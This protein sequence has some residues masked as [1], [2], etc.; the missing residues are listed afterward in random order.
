MADP[1][2]APPRAVVLES[3]SDYAGETDNLVDI[4]RDG[5]TKAWFDYNGVLHE[6]T[7][8]WDDLLGPAASGL[9]DAG[10]VTEAFAD[11]AFTAT[12]W[13]YDRDDAICWTLQTSHRWDRTTSLYFHVHIVPMANP[14]T[15]Q[16]IRFDGSYAWASY[17]Q[18][19]PSNSG[20]TAIPA[21][22]HTV[23]PGDG[24]KATIVPLVTIAPPALVLES[25]IL[26]IRVRRPGNSDAA[27]TY[28]TS[29]SPGSAKANVCI[30]SGDAHYRVNKRGTLTEIP[31]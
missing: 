17:G 10:M 2:V 16:V 12:F 15:A 27:D 6:S 31:S 1:V 3:P 11:T 25:D 7:E 21:V 8:A 26:L 23:N 19:V 24:M 5:I 22:S 18:T 4:K 28:Q 30:L 9:K 20:W 14:A 29:K 13:E